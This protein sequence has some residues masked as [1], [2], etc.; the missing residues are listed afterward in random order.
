MAWKSCIVF[1]VIVAVAACQSQA[2]A[3]A[4]TEIQKVQ[5]GDLDVV[6]LAP[7]TSLKQGADD[8]FTVEFRRS[9]SNTL[10]DVGTVKVSATMPMAG[11]PAMKANASA[12]PTGT[13]G[14]Y[15]VNSHLTMA[16]TWNFAVEW[17]GPAGSGSA[18]LSANAQ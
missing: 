10:I 13:P 9:G 4:G 2:P 16:G 8:A 12:M 3:T 15:T 1:A 18:E 14:R 17:H 6:L 7:S 11:M 5:A